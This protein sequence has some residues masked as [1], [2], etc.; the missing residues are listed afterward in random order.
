MITDLWQDLG[1]GARTLLKQPGFAL[2]AVLILALGIGSTTT[3]FSAIYNILLDPSTLLMTRLPVTTSDWAASRYGT[4]ARGWPTWQGRSAILR[5][6]PK[7]GRTG[8]RS[9]KC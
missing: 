3:I 5:L 2:L 7:C 4:R 9:T 8:T 6:R 1:Y